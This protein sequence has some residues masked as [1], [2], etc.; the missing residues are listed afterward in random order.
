MKHSSKKHSAIKKAILTLKKLRR[1][2]RLG[3]KLTIKE[4]IEA[5][6]K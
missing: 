3:K 5:G 6:K 4:M 1:G 2:V